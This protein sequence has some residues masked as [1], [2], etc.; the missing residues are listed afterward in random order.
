MAPQRVSFSAK[1]IVVTFWSDVGFDESC[2]V[3]FAV[4]HQQKVVFELCALIKEKI[5]TEN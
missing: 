2:I 4:Q 5:W 1:Y 3:S